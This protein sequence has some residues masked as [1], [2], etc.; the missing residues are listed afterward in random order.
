MVSVGGVYCFRPAKESLPFSCFF[1]VSLVAFILDGRFLG[2]ADNGGELKQVPGDEKS[3]TE[4]TEHEASQDG[5]PA[6]G[7]GTVLFSYLFPA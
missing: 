6:D 1:I 2:L 4:S 7:Q 5:P 3:A